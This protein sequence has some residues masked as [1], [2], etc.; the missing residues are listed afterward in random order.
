MSFESTK[1]FFDDRNFPHGFHRSGDFTRAQAAILEA[2]G[3]TLK[4]LHEG[5]QAPQGPEEERFVAVCK[6][7]QP[8]STDIEKTWMIYLSALRRKQVYFTASSATMAD[9]NG[10]SSDSDD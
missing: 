4:A 5:S 3:I 6:G 1:K 2:K 8:T 9:G 10:D 7:E